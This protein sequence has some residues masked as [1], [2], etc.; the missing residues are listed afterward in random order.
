M[1]TAATPEP[2]PPRARDAAAARS[3]RRLSL[4]WWERGGGRNGRSTLACQRNNGSVGLGLGRR[5]LL[6]VEVPVA[7]VLGVAAAVGAGAGCGG[8]SGDAAAA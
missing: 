8:G 7:L 4:V 2:T 3:H 1:T 5:T 6:A